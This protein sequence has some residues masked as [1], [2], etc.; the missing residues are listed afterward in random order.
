MESKFIHQSFPNTP[1]DSDNGMDA[2]YLSGPDHLEG[3]NVNPEPFLQYSDSLLP[4]LNIIPSV[5]NA[6]L[7]MWSPH[8]L[9]QSPDASS[10]NQSL[11]CD[12][13]WENEHAHNYLVGPLSC[14]IQPHAQNS[15]DVHLSSS[16]G[17][18]NLHSPTS[19]WSEEGRSDCSS[20]MDDMDGTSN[21]CRWDGGGS[22][23]SLLTSDKSEV[24]KHLQLLHGVKSGGD[25]DKMSCEWH[26]CG[27]V[28]KKESISRHVV[29][30]HMSNKT[31]CD[32]CGKQFA[33]LD[34][35][36]RH[37]KNSKREEC[38]ESEPYDS[39]AKRRRLSCP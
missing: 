34:S 30:V 10:S 18:A 21:F 38:R 35:K 24:A 1:L 14:D 17:G 3:R 37:L 9:P 31:E 39:R 26:G 7:Q 22:C 28:M 8:A 29:A 15:S 27:K 25:K 2:L 16:C 12:Y 5:D 6:S 11:F 20:V 13:T 19:S 4:E 33:R 32:S 23:T 36:L